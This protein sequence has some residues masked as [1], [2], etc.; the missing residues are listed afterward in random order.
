MLSR[1]LPYLSELHLRTFAPH[2]AS[3][4]I[5]DQGVLSICKHMKYLKLLTLCMRP[6]II[7]D[8]NNIGDVGAVEIA[9]A[10]PNLLEL[11]MSTQ[12]VI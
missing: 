11:S 5:T 4:R 1:N 7:V 8:E 3:N 2:T 12:W 6:K 9:H 10:M